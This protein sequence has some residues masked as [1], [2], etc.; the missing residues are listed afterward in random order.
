MDIKRVNE[1]RDELK[2]MA[3]KEAMRLWRLARKAEKKGC[4]TALVREIREEAS[5][6]HREA[7]VYQERIICWKFEYEHKFCVEK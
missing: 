4:S 7:T 2:E 1:I 3:E 6:L 5:W